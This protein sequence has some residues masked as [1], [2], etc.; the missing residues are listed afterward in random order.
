MTGMPA[1]IAALEEE[2]TDL[3]SK[4][5]QANFYQDFPA[6]FNEKSRRIVAAKHELEVSWQRWQ[7]LESL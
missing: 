1:K 5:A 2:I 7:E 4:L 3:E 6:E